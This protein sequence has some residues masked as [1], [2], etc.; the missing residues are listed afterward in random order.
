[1]A[2]TLEDK[3]TETPEEI[4]ETKVPNKETLAA[5]QELKEGKGISF[6]SIDEL[7]KYLKS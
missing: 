6:T 3:K 1:M 2:T 4:S 7:F 5:C